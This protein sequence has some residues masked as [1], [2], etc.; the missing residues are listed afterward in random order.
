MVC[1]DMS[2]SLCQR[3]SREHLHSSPISARVLQI[4]PVARLGLQ[5]VQGADV[6]LLREELL[7]AS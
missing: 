2:K 5:R 3:R 4:L 7:A 1:L 6:L